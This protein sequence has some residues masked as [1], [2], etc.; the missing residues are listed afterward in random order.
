MSGFTFDTKD[1][2]IKFTELV[3]KTIP[4][5]AGDALFKA[6][7]LVIRDSILEEPTVPKKTGNLRRTQ[8]I[9]PAE[10]GDDEISV[11]V[12]FN[13][14][15]AAKV[16]EMGEGLG[17]L[18]GNVRSVHW[19]LPGSGPKFLSTKLAKNKEKYMQFVAD[20]ILKASEA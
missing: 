9:L 3:K 13:A 15:Y 17:F 11:D 20:E 14:D 19:T 10:I 7:A 18:W 5:L 4:R 6:G 12:G 2:D 1:F 16:H 8:K